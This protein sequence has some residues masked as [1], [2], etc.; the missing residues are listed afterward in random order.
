MIL[1]KVHHLLLN[2]P[3]SGGPLNLAGHLRSGLRTGAAQPRRLCLHLT[4]AL[5][6]D[7]CAYNI[8]IV[9]HIYISKVISEHQTYNTHIASFV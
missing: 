4:T 3:S 8:N 2:P 5:L 9:L 7:L 6:L 1:L